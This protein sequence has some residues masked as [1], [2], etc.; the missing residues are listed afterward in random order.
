MS[1]PLLTEIAESVQLKGH[2]VVSATAASFGFRDGQRNFL[3]FALVGGAM[4]N[5]N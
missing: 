2:G 4:G 1:L 5:E 3:S